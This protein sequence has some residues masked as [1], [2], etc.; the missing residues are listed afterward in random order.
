MYHI[1][2]R[3]CNPQ[4]QHGDSDIAI[5]CGIL[6]PMKQG[7]KE[8]KVSF[9][10]RVYKRHKTMVRELIPT[11]PGVE[12]RPVR[13]KQRK[14]PLSSAEVVCIAIEKLHKSRVKNKK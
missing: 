9:F 13:G 4:G 1:R 7:V 2:Y 3:F 8:N 6:S 5:G 12:T 11:F 14:R 10:T